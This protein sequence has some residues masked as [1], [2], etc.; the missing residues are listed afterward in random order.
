MTR[1]RV[2]GATRVR[3]LIR[4]LPDAIEA[5]LADRMEAGGGKMLVAMRAAAPKRT[6]RLRA[7]YSMKMNRKTLRLR[8]GLNGR[9][10]NR[11]LFYGR[12]LEFGRK[13]KSVIIKRGPRR[14]SFMR[15]GA[16]APGRFVFGAGS[17]ALKRFRRELHGVWR[18]ILNDVAR[19]GDVE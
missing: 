5:E 9:K 11:D 17:D 6:G 1:K 15:I 14:G 8:V 18:S 19:G 13:S 10:V 3:R 7:G 2:K 4:R 16:I 12:I